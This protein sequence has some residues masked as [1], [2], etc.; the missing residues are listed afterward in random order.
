MR[1]PL[2][3]AATAI[4]LAQGS[5]ADAS[6]GAAGPAFVPMAE[7]VVPIVD[8]AQAYGRL[9]IKLVLLAHDAASVAPIQAQMPAMRE[10][11]LIAA[12]E[13]ARLHASPFAPIDA[14]RL[15]QAISTAMIAQGKD[16]LFTRVLLVGV[17]AERS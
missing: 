12:A 8:G 1:R 15:A 3:L 10:T 5:T 6:E 7:I 16:H 4:A 9:R 2:Y 14:R 11:A 17:F 13:F